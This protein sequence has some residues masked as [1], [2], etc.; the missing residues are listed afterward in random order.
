MG[1]KR[2]LGTAD[3]AWIVA[4]NM[5]GAGIFVMPGQVANH[6]PG[7]AWILAAWG[8][9]GLLALAGAMVYGELGS[10]Y[11]RAG[12]DY[13][14]LHEAF[15]PLPAFLS[16]WAAFTLTFSAAAA[17]MSIAALDHLREAFPPLTG[18]QGWRVLKGA[19][20]RTRFPPGLVRR[21]TCDWRTRRP[22][23]S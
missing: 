12:G 16:G 6:L 13:R 9:G 2:V 15:G 4:G 23:T 8:V 10:R 7:A 14:Y 5:I 18:L 20:P 1:L 19:T 17:A 22:G 21:T 3:A 11:P